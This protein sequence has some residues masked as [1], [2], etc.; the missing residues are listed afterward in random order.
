MRDLAGAKGGGESGGVGVASGVGDRGDGGGGVAPADRD[1]V[2]GPGG[3]GGGEG[4]GDGGRRGLGHSVVAL[5]EGDR[6]GLSCGRTRACG[7]E[8]QDH[9]AYHATQSLQAHTS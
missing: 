1:D 2:E 6:G 4:D 8:R 7:D 3:L 9:G 5:H